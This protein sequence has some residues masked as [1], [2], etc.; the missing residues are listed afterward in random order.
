[1]EYILYY[2]YNETCGSCRKFHTIIDQLEQER[3]CLKV[4]RI[5]VDQNTHPEIA[6]TPTIVISYS[7]NELGRFSS[8]IS[9]RSIDSWLDQIEVY[10]TN[11]LERDN[12]T[13]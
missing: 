6:Y 3:P 2:Y 5:Q 11:Y 9:K 13:T 12:L 8:A 7:N 10:I 4:E 1:M